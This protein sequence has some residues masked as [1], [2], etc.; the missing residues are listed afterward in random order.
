MNKTNGEE[1]SNKKDNQVDMLRSY[2]VVLASL[3][4]NKIILAPCYDSQALS[5]SM[6]S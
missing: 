6:S 3:L 2:F 4:V 5:I 1:G